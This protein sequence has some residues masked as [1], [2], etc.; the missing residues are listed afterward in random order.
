MLVH[1]FINREIEMVGLHNSIDLFN[2][3]DDLVGET[4]V[5]F[6]GV[7]F[8]VGCSPIRCSGN[9]AKPPKSR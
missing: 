2:R 4:R 6:L 7:S 3:Y 1:R 9:K 5:H 8:L